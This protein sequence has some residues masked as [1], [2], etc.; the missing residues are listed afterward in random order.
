MESSWRLGVWENGLANAGIDLFARRLTQP[1]RGVGRT[2]FL[3]QSWPA[4]YVNFGDDRGWVYVG[5][6]T[7]AYPHFPYGIAVEP[8]T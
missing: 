4:F 3:Y 6:E 5:T 8:D 7:P 2:T 1:W